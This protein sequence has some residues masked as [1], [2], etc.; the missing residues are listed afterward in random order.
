MTPRPSVEH[1]VCRRHG[2]CLAVAP[3]AFSVGADGRIQVTARADDA[4]LT[5]ARQA[6]R[7]CPTQAIQV[8]A[9]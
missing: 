6:A 1:R 4:A 5:K 7:L 9:S 8:A 3:E 2:L